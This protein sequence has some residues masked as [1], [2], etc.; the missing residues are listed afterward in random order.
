MRTFLALRW[1]S[2][3]CVAVLLFLSCTPPSW[4]EIRVAEELAKKFQTPLTDVVSVPFQYNTF[5]GVGPG[6]ATSH[7]LNISPIVPV[8]LGDWHIITRTVIPVIS[9]SRFT[10]GLEDEIPGTGGGSATGLATLISPRLSRPGAPGPYPGEWGRL[11]PSRPRQGR[12]SAV[13]SGVPGH[14]PW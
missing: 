2:A 12:S 3:C 6:N 14:R 5:F 10:P 8:R 1:S 13:R 7:L 11:S 9:V 4:A